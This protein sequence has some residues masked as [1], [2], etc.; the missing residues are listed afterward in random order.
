MSDAP[1]GLTGIHKVAD[2]SWEPRRAHKVADQSH[3]SHG[4]LSDC[5]SH[6]SECSYKG[7]GL[8]KEQRREVRAAIRAQWAEAQ[9]ELQMIMSALA[10]KEAELEVA[11]GR[12][13]GRPGCLRTVSGQVAP[14]RR[15]MFAMHL[16]P[17]GVQHTVWLA[18]IGEQCIVGADVLS[19]MASSWTWKRTYCGSRMGPARF[20]CDW[21]GAGGKEERSPVSLPA[22][23]PASKPASYRATQHACPPVSLAACPPAYQTASYRA[24]QQDCLLTSPVVCQSAVKTHSYAMHARKLAR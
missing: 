14:M 2:A 1:R 18:D 13:D 12:V 24:S 16:G 20:D 4:D 7:L 5:I 10:V 11:M 8:I 17:V 9:S 6:G 21:R 3:R 22:A 15:Q 23:M 19:A